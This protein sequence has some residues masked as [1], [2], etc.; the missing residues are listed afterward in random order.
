MSPTQA[1][2]IPEASVFS[3]CE[4][5]SL[6]FKGIQHNDL[7]RLQLSLD[8]QIVLKADLYTPADSTEVTL[9]RIDDLLLPF[10]RRHLRRQT[11]SRV[12]G[13]VYPF[14]ESLPLPRLSITVEGFEDKKVYLIPSTIDIGISISAFM[15]SHFLTLQKGTKL[16]YHG[17]EELLSVGHLATASPAPLQ[18]FALWYYEGNVTTTTETI[19]APSSQ[20]YSCD[21][22]IFNSRSFTP[23]HPLAVLISYRATLTRPNLPVLTQTYQ[24][25]EINDAPATTFHFENSFGV[26]ETFHAFGDTEIEH[27]QKR[28]ISELRQGRAMQDTEDQTAYEV[29]TGGVPREGWAVFADLLRSLNVWA[30]GEPVLITDSTAKES[31]SPYR[32]SSGSI[33]YEKIHGE[34]VIFYHKTFDPT[35]DT[36]F[37]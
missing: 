11:E 21:C 2:L 31:N 18:I 17:A 35:F 25:E 4:L 5:S 34:K 14:V 26:L 37:D 27:K 15:Q 24:V 20:P 12:F 19:P 28:T 6:S 10:L 32:L 22:Y 7:L 3:L 23:P 13:V 9:Y 16:T 29:E 30:N 8:D 33:K 36:T 1:I